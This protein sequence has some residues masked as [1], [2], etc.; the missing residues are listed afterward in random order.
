MLQERLKKQLE[1][2]GHKQKDKLSLTFISHEVF[3]SSILILP[4]YN[5]LLQVRLRK[6]LEVKNIKGNNLGAVRRR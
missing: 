1:E 4:R 6:K 5:V 3:L 2:K